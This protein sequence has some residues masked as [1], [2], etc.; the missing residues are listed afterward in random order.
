MRSDMQKGKNMMSFKK[1]S[2]IENSF[3]RQFMECVMTEMPT[4]LQYVI[5]EKGHGA[6]TSFLCDGVE[7]LFAKRTS[8]L[9]HKI[10][11]NVS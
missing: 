5:Q 4:D 9:L 3:N 10:V 1:Y 6:N 8:V 7:V 2:S 11:S